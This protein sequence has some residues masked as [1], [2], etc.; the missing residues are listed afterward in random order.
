MRRAGRTRYIFCKPLYYSRI[1]TD[2]PGLFTKVGGLMKM[3]RIIQEWRVLETKGQP[4][5]SA[6]V[7][8]IIGVGKDHDIPDIQL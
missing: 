1:E 2:S 8:N 7:V 3:E 4:K 6:Q 5:D